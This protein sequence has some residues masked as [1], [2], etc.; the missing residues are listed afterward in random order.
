MKFKLLTF[1]ALLSIFSLSGCEDKGIKEDIVVKNEQSNAKPQKIS[2][3]K[4]G[5]N[6]INNS[7]LNVQTAEDGL[8]IEEF[9]DKMV[10]VVFFATW[11]P[12]CKAEIPHL[13]H[14]QNKYKKDFVVIG[15]SVDKQ[16]MVQDMV[17]FVKEHK[18]NY[19]IT[20]GESNFDLANF[21]GGVQSIPTMLLFDKKGKFKQIYKGA[22]HEEILDADINKFLK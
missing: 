13:I 2:Y 5:L 21:V 9:K 4:I 11:C 16:K 3:P 6:T 14:L 7:I 1:I 15:V 22:V 19:P 18:I 10:L 20:L 8:V 12:P 17:S